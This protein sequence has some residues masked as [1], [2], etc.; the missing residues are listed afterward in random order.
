MPR[1]PYER[2]E[3]PDLARCPVVGLEVDST[4][5]RSDWHC[6]R[7]AQLLY[8]AAGSVTLYFAERICQLTPLQAAWLPA[9]VPHRTVLHG[10][11][12]YRSLYFEPSAFAELPDSVQVHEVGALMRELILRM[13]GWAADLQLEGPHLTLLR[14]LFDELASAPAHAAS[15]PMP[16]DARALKVAEALLAQPAL[17]W[18]IEAWGREVGASGRTLARLFTEQTGLG[19]SRWRTQ[20]RLFEARRRLAEGRSVTEV[21]HALGY[22]SDSAFIAMYRRVCGQSPGRALRGLE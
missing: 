12:A 2:V 1:Y 5:H 22:A 7:R 9:G 11:F 8:M 3:D 16:R 15:L 4:G 10:R 18:S 6:H 17:D 13:T 14:A 20:A 21:A 19:F